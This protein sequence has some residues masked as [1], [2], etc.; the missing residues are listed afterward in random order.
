M[1]HALTL[2]LR[3][4]PPVT[5]NHGASTSPAGFITG[6][7]TM[8]LRCEVPSIDCTDMKFRLSLLHGLSLALWSAPNVLGQSPNDESGKYVLPEGSR[9]NYFSLHIGYD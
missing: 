6:E 1:R 3:Y 2:Y 7:S 8:S 4:Q 5:Q 9:M